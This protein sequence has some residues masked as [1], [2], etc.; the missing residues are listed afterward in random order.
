ML[1]VK[2]ELGIVVQVQ[3][4]YEPGFMEAPNEVLPGY[5][6]QL[7]GTFSKPVPSAEAIASKN[8]TLAKS[9][10]D[11]VIES[12]INVNGA[13]W[14]IDKLKDEP[15][16]KRAIRVAEF[17]GLPDTTEVEWILADNSVRTTTLAELKVVL[18]AKAYRERDIFAQYRKWREGSMSTAFKFYDI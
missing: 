15:R 8:A 16:I 11:T 7:D 18:T 4:Y 10:R 2:V 9:Y 14:Q 1:Y 17:N 13:M 5:E 3:P 6:L 12:D